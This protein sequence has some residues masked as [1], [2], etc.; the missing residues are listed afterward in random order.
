MSK[1][2]D[3][4][5]LVLLILATAGCLSYGQVNSLCESCSFYDEVCYYPVATSNTDVR[6]RRMCNQLRL[7]CEICRETY[8]QQAK[9]EKKALL[10]E[11]MA[12]DDE[13]TKRCLSCSA[14]KDM[15]LNNDNV[16][17]ILQKIVFE[18]HKL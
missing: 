17:N 18:S 3:A 8:F 13:R 15:C 11:S 6:N 9:D 10:E 7:E 4:I 16:R 1:V 14:A 2:S 12:A 5:L